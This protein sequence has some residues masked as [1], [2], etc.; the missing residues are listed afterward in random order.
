MRRDDSDRST[1]IRLKRAYSPPDNEDG[2]RVLVDRLWI[3]GVAKTDARLDAWMA[4]LGPSAELRTW[5][6]HQ[7]DRWSEFVE[8]Y[9][10]ELETPLRRLFLTAL[11]GVAAQSTLTL[12]YGAR[13]E[14]E[15]EAVVLRDLL[16]RGGVNLADRWDAPARVLALTA[17]VA[18]ANGD[19]IATRSGVRRFASSILSEDEIDN[20]FQTLAADGRLRD[21]SSGWSL[22]TKGRASARQL[23]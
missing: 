5:F 9:Q 23:E 13:D 2:V 3:R 21:V 11:Q 10:S 7:P 18:A 16:E 8:K 14:R 12:V 20:A 1:R 15:N 22:T 4:P 17:A 6:G 19:A